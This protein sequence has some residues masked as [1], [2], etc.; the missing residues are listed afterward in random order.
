MISKPRFDARRCDGLATIYRNDLSQPS[1]ATIYR[2]HL[3]QPSITTI[4]RNHL[5]RPSIATIYRNHLS[6]PSIATIYCNDL[7]IETMSLSFVSTTFE[8]LLAKLVIGA[9]LFALAN[10]YR[11]PST[12]IIQFNDEVSDLSDELFTIVDSSIIWGD[13]NCPGSSPTFIDVRLDT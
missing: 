4:Y 7:N 12:G 1:I 5:S 3:L 10:I 13:V 11:P 2:N 6:Q 9:E 8:V